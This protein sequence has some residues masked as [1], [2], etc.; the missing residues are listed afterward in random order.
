MWMS[1]GFVERMRVQD[2][3]WIVGADRATLDERRRAASPQEVAQLL[4]SRISAVPVEIVRAL[5]VGTA[6]LL[7][8]P[9]SL[10]AD[11]RGAR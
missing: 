1:P 3:L 6:L 2:D 10:R 8:P 4:R 11:A 5:E 9:S 7:R